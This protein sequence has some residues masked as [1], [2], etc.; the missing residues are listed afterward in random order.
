MAVSHRQ[1]YFYDSHFGF[2]L[3]FVVVFFVVVLFV[4]FM[5]PCHHICHRVSLYTL[6]LAHSV[7]VQMKK[8]FLVQ[9]GKLRA[10]FSVQA[11]LVWNNIPAHIRHCS[12]L[13]RSKNCSLYFCLL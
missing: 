4:F 6:P 3:F 11:P 7:P 1:V 8:L 10:L 9:D 13:S 12:S 2:P 5:V